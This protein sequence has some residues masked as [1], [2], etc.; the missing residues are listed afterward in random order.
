MR[1]SGLSLL[2]LAVLLGSACAQDAALVS[3][4][5]AKFLMKHPLLA[6][7]HLA[8]P[9][10]VSGAPAAVSGAPGASVTPTAV[11]AQCQSVAQVAQQAGSFSSLLAAAQAAG[12]A[13]ALSDRS[14]QATVFAPTD[15]AFADALA[16]LD[17]SAQELAAQPALLAAILKYHVVPGAPITTAQMGDSQ[18]LPTLL[19]ADLA[20]AASASATPSWHKQGDSEDGVLT[21][22]VKKVI[23][24]VTGQVS[25]N[26]TVVGSLSSASIITPDVQA[27]CPA[28]VHVIDSVL[29]PA[30]PPL[31]DDTS[32]GGM[33]AALMKIWG[34]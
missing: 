31:V 15:A 13:P 34:Q 30:I 20:A 5:R 16:A 29:L 10:A 1:R 23:S 6:K 8:P 2:L 22:D 17:V 26:I 32:A 19:S 9:V 33:W 24:L 11:P 12:L 25:K 18:K 4:M 28:V 27:G 14:L 7:H 3:G 21:L